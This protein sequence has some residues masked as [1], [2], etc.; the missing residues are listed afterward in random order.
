[1]CPQKQYNSMKIYTLKAVQ[2]LPIPV[3]EA[4]DFFSTPVN[5]TLITPPAMNFRITS[6]IPPRIYPG[7]IITYRVAVFSGV[8]A[9]WVTEISH[10]REPHYFVDE[11]RFGPYSFWHHKHFFRELAGGVEMED[12]VHYGL[13]FGSLGRAVHPWM[14]RRKLEGIFSY[15][16][17]TLLKR[18]GEYGNN[19][20]AP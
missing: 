20:D 10:V 18:F 6:D 1:M 4:W 14:V 2:K 9:T 12:L 3:Q 5:L 16:R 17:E 15:R 19:T 7:A 13:P 8:T 11:Q